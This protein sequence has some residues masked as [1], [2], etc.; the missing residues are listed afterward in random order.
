M[1][2]RP[3]FATSRIRRTSRDGFTLIEIMIVVIILGI[4]AS[5][6]IPQFSNA[7]TEAREATLKED[8]RYLRTQIGAYKIQHRDAAPGYPGG[9]ITA[10]PDETSFLDQMTR[11]SDELSNT[12]T[13]QSPVYRLGPYL[14]KMPPNPLNGKTGVLVDTSAT[15]PAADNS[16]PHGWIYNPVLQKIQVN[17]AG[18][19]S[20]GKPYASY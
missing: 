2:A 6:A 8:L 3:A 19:D 4:L 16:Q 17:L 11:F 13:A 9:D 5:V 1:Y 12:S 10:T 7:S 14:S 18:A 20:S 15:M